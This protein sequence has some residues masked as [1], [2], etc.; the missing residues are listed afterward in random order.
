MRA[1]HLRVPVFCCLFFLARTAVFLAAF[2]CSLFS[3][4]YLLSFTSYFG[5][6][7]SVFMCV[8]LADLVI[9]CILFACERGLEVSCFFLLYDRTWISLWC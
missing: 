1:V 7:D 8:L 6:V 5:A 2:L 3:G 4:R 9:Q